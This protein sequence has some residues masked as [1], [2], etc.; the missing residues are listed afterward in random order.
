MQQ[1]NRSRSWWQ[2]LL[3]AAVQK[4]HSALQQVPPAPTQPDVGLDVG[5]GEVCTSS[6]ACWSITDNMGPLTAD[7]LM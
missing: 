2:P 7:S 6:C 1:A 5:G 3:L 4:A